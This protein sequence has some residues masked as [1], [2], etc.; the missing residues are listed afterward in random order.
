M[1]IS[2][3]ILIIPFFLF[4]TGCASIMSDPMDK[5]P[6]ELLKQAEKEFKKERFEKTREFLEVLKARDAEKKYYV[7]AIIL[8][9][10]SYFAQGKYLEAGMEYKAFLD[11]HTYHKKAPYAQY[12]LARSYFEQIDSVD[13]SFENILIARREFQNLLKRYRKNPYRKSALAKIVRCN[14]LLAEYEDYVGSFYLKKRAYKA[15]IGRFE[16]LIKEFPQSSV[17]V[18]VLLKLGRAYKEMGN[19]GK[20]KEILSL[21]LARYPSSQQAATAKEMLDRF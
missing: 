10:D 17:E 5:P 15:A 9:A 16:T 1:K 12:M 3:L 19:P 6:V 4:F 8:T 2:I 14:D 11:L 13:R 21:L 20:A 7:K 18:D